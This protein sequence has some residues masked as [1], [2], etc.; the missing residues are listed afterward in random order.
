MIRDI[1]CQVLGFLWCFSEP[2]AQVAGHRSAIN[3]IAGAR[4]VPLPC[5][6]MCCSPDLQARPEQWGNCSLSMNLAAIQMLA[7]VMLIASICGG[8][9][10]N[11]ATC[12]MSGFLIFWARKHLL[13]F[14]YEAGGSVFDS[15]EAV[16]LAFRVTEYS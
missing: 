3:G 13:V 2:C 5:P 9:V 6:H 12:T 10:C 14:S 8:W 11:A 16:I 4:W 1:M 15:P 7:V